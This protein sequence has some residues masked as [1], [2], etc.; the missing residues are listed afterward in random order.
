MN[1]KGNIII[2]I[3][4]TLTTLLEYVDPLS[5]YLTYSKNLEGDKPVCF[6][7]IALKMRF[8]FGPSASRSGSHQ[9]G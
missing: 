1:P 7:Y 4:L 3:N 5:I 8:V 2:I 9:P 6:V